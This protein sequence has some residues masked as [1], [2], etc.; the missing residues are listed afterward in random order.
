MPQPVPS[1]RLGARVERLPAPIPAAWAWRIRF[2]TRVETQISRIQRR[3]YHFRD[4]VAW[5]TLRRLG[6]DD[7]LLDTAHMR[8]TAI[9]DPIYDAARTAHWYI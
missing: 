1:Q 9:F 3:H 8:H 2:H 7:R 4:T 6:I 5:P